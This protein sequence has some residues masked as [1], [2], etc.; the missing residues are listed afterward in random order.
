MGSDRRRLAQTV[1]VACV[2]DVFTGVLDRSC[3]NIV[4]VGL[5]PPFPGKRPAFSV[6]VSAM[7][8]STTEKKSQGGVASAD[9]T[10]GNAS[11]RVSSR[12]VHSSSS[13]FGRAAGVQWLVDRRP[14]ALLRAEWRVGR[15]Q[16]LGRA[17][18]RK[19]GAS[20]VNGNIFPPWGR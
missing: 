18:H 9:H 15:A 13:I 11:L 20:S 6:M 16:N 10:E 8:S 4:F 7:R 17:S 14:T 3:S 1:R 12:S 19:R 2:G 5:I